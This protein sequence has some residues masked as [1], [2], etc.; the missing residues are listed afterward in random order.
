MALGS[1]G[2]AYARWSQ[3][4]SISGTVSLGRVAF[5]IAGVGTLDTGPDP[6]EPPERG[7]SGLDVAKHTSINDTSKFIG[8]V[9]EIKFFEAV[10]EDII[11]V[12]PWYRSGTSLLLGNLGTIPVKITG[13]NLE[14]K[15]GDPVIMDFLEISNWRITGGK[16]SK[17]L[18]GYGLAALK[19]ALGT[20]KID[21]G[22][23]VKLTI[24]FYFPE[25]ANGRIMPNSGN[26]GFTISVIATQWNAENGVLVGLENSRPFVDRSSVQVKIQNHRGIAW[27]WQNST[28]SEY[29]KAPYL[30]GG[31]LLHIELDVSDADGED[32]LGSMYVRANV[33]QTVVRCS[34]VKY[35]GLVNETPTA[36]YAGDW[37]VDDTT[38]Q[39]I[40]DFNLAATDHNGQ[41]DRHDVNLNEGGDVM[42]KPDISLSTVVPV[43][44]FPS[45]G[46]G[47]NGIGAEKNPINIK[48]EALIGEKHIP[49][50]FTIR[51]AS[52]DMQ[53]THGGSVIP[54]NSISWSFASTR[55]EATLLG[56]DFSTLASDVDEGE[57]IPVLYWLNIP[58]TQK[59]GEYKGQINYDLVPQ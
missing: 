21:P 6:L 57:T 27:E 17:D 12:Y 59:K 33:G 51:H 22:Q 44:S 24:E 39:G 2:V 4:L 37:L 18:E 54:A 9:N 5:G 41:T 11:N 40:F 19:N 50:T 52:T 1:L 10:N 43:I 29:R 30:F 48:P 26:L 25:E 20:I 56:T 36:H 58:D 34:L 53:S 8:E 45:A 32:D 42:V 14:T 13:F 3:A 23:V 46:P 47:I 31:E 55:T 28:L 35:A 16:L 15:S 7:S 49:V 38:V